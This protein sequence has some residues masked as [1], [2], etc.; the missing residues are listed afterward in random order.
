MQCHRKRGFRPG[1][2]LFISKCLDKKTPKKKIVETLKPHKNHLQTVGLCVKDED[3]MQL[4]ALFAQA[5]LLRITSGR[6]MSR[7]LPGEAHDGAY[8]LREYSRIVEIDEP[9]PNIDK[10]ENLF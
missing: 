1:I 10:G 4:S 3:R 6:A 5:G 2:I 8:P 9:I 7:V